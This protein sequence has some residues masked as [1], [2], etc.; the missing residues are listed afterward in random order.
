ML[1]FA[2][3]EILSDRPLKDEFDP[4]P[5]LSETTII[6]DTARL[7]WEREIYE[8]CDR[9]DFDISDGKSIE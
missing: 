6:V 4:E 1:T 7:D 8:Q 5:H 2:E 9:E 3:K